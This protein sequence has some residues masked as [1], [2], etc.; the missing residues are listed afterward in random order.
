MPS[1]IGLVTKACAKSISAAANLLRTGG[2]VA[3]PTE[4]VYGL[5]G[6]A[7]NNDAVARIFEAKGRPS[8]NPLICHV[9]NID[10]AREIAVFSPL[11]EKFADAFWPGPLTLVLPRTEQ[12][13]V[14]Q[15]VSAGME[16]IAVRVPANETA[17][18]L[19]RAVG[20]P[21]AAP[22]AN[23]SGGISPTKAAHVNASLG[24]NI[25]MVLDGGTCDIGLESTILLCVGDKISLLRSGGLETETIEKFLGTTKLVVAPDDVENAPLAPG[26]LK[27]HYA[28]RAKVRTD[29]TSVK[30]GES[31]LA[32]GPDLLDGFENAHMVLNLSDTGNLVEAAANLF[33]F[34]HQLDETGALVIACAKVP[35]TGLGVA[36][37]DRLRRAAAP[38]D[39]N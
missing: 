17:Q 32:F 19:L 13:P 2:L 33:D 25:D 18:A 4:T 10:A 20:R 27:S 1:D 36:I 6:D 14:S 30:H 24:D 29:I 7:T 31:L 12:S 28:P 11:A 38:R 39:K 23:A 15:L 34:L 16:T 5:G 21:V 26:R 8:F 37:N 22:S 3:F 35:E 9:A